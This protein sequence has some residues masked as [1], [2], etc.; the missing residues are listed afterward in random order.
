MKQKDAEVF[1]AAK[2]HSEVIL[3]CNDVLKLFIMYLPFPI[4]CMQIMAKYE[5]LWREHEML[6]DT[7]AE[8]KVYI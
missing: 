5:K 2:Q 8:A 4:I 6:K 3:E 7:S 1:D